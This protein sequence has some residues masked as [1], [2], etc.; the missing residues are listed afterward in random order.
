[1]DR[2]TKWR[3][4]ILRRRCGVA[5]SMSSL[6]AFVTSRFFGRATLRNGGIVATAIL[7][8][9]SG[10]GG[11]SRLHSVAFR[12]AASGRRCRAF[13]GNPDASP[14]RQTGTRGVLTTDERMKS[15]SILH[16]CR[17]V[18]IG[19]RYSSPRFLHLG[20][21]TVSDLDSAGA[22][23]GRDLVGSGLETLCALGVL[24]RSGR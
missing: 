15:E 19:G 11:R 10:W 8:E 12:N 23:A 2:G 17:S 20:G 16:L 7:P 9:K 18:L 3:A 21:K 13:F 24:E 5:G 22:K 6:R 14:R 4:A 1:M